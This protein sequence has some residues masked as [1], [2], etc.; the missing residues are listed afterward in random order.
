MNDKV[1]GLDGNPV[2]QPVDWNTSVVDILERAIADVKHNKSHSVLVATVV[3]TEDGFDIECYWHGKRL[4][5]LAGAAR[6]AHRLNLQCDDA[7]VVIS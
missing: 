3:P 6:I 7:V 4:S 1:V 5:L 2:E